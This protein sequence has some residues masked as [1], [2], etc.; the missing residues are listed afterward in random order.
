MHNLEPHT[1]IEASPLFRDLQPR[2]TADVLARLQPVSFTRETRIL[3]RGSWHGQLYIVATGLVSVLLQEDQHEL[4]VAH[5]GPGEC[6]G[7]MSLITGEPPSA[8]VRTEQDSSL[9]AL[10]QA[11]FL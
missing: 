2:E 1:L 4:A 9:W 8:T 7:E 6:F 10:P 11:D 3:E 5:L